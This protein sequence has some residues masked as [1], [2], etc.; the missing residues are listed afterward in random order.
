VILDTALYED[1]RAELIRPVNITTNL[2]RLPTAF[3]LYTGMVHYT[4]PSCLP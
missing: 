4:T 1:G 2:R 3:K